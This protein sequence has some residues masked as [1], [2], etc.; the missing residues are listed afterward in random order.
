MSVNLSINNAPAEVVERL[1]R[2]ARRHRRSLQAELLAIVEEAVSDE[3]VLT[4]AELL[5]HVQR[6]GLQTPSESAAIVRA[7]RDES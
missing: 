2:R 6:I 3:G 1:R 5:V 4:P 7:A